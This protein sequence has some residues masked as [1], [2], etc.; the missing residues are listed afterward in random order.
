MMGLLQVSR[1]QLAGAAMQWWQLLPIL[2]VHEQFLE[3]NK[4]EI[5]RYRY[6][7]EPSGDGDQ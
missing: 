4:Q 2:F 5:F 1:D 7:P 6:R 3:L